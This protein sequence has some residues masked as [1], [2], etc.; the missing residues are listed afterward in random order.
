MLIEDSHDTNRCFQ[1]KWSLTAHDKDKRTSSPSSHLGTPAPQKHELLVSLRSSGE[2]W[3]QQMM[4]GHISK[5]GSCFRV[6]RNCMSTAS[7]RPLLI[8]RAI[9][10][11]WQQIAK[12][13]PYD[14]HECT[15]FS[16]V[17]CSPCRFWNPGS[18]DRSM[19]NFLNRRK[20][21]FR[22]DLAVTSIQDKFSGSHTD[23]MPV[24][25]SGGPNIQPSKSPLTL[26]PHFCC[27][28]GKSSH[29]M[30][31]II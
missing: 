19:I 7:A 26:P 14:Q 5:L 17:H 29:S 23:I 20:E 24:S 22:K 31:A 25:R 21:N 2:Q 30:N 18:M 11:Q 3:Q 12:M 1:S 9:D 13:Q 16:H 8:R 27:S 15:I 10:V 4:A 6:Q 28:C